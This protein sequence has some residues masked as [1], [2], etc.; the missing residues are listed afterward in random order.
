MSVDIFL[1]ICLILNNLV[2]ILIIVKTEKDINKQLDRLEDKIDSRTHALQDE[3]FY[4]K[5]GGID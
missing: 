1:F 2:I 4:V 3:I 5:Q